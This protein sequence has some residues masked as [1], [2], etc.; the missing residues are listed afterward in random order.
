MGAYSAMLEGSTQTDIQMATRQSVVDDLGLGG[1]S[2]TFI[3][4]WIFDDRSLVSVL[5]SGERS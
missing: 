2:Q 1:L 4:T 5:E 3:W